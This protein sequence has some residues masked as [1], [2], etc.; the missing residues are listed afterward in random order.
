M[1]LKTDKV[2]SYNH[3]KYNIKMP[4]LT[5]LNH[6]LL[7]NNLTMVINGKR[8]SGKT[9]L[10]F[11]LLTTPE[12]LDFNN[13]MIYSKTIDQY[14]YQFIE[15]GFKYNFKKDVINNLLNSKKKI[16]KTCV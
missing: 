11:N 9:T 1:K 15:Q 4:R 13:L 6:D 16:S 3:D 10:L 7:T 2:F 12:I 5:R 14:L 8:I